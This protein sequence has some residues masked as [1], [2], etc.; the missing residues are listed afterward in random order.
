MAS[1]SLEKDL[2]KAP[3]EAP[4]EAAKKNVERAPVLDVV[5]PVRKWDI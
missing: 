3:E 5:E 1:K 4:K 2:E